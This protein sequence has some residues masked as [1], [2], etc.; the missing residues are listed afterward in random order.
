M[1][2]DG[3]YQSDLDDVVKQIYGL[4]PSDLGERFGRESGLDIQDFR[5]CSADAQSRVAAV[6]GS[7]SMILEAGLLTIAAVRAVVSCYAGGKREFLSTTPLRLVRLGMEDEIVNFISIYEGCFGRTPE[8]G[9]PGDDRSDAVAVIRDTLEHSAALHALDRMEAGDLLLLDGGLRV[10]HASHRPVLN[11]LLVK[12]GANDVMVA[13]ISKHSSVTWGDGLPLVL[14]VDRYARRCGIR[15]PYYVRIPE[16]L[17]DR[18]RYGQWQRGVV[19]VAKLH[20]RAPRAFKIEVPDYAG[21]KAVGDTFQA[22]AAYADDARVPGYPF[23]L[24]DA[25]RKVRITEDIREH[26]FNDLIAE[27]NRTGMNREDFMQLF[28]DYHDEFNRY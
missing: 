9:L 24:L 16:E 13:G 14:S 28:G 1:N 19:Y 4:C 2:G 11:D 10:S 6:D 3:I 23:P 18:H 26:I 25:H 22:C 20:P 5:R 21:D 17:M 12:A 27:M 15:P 8:S 7:N